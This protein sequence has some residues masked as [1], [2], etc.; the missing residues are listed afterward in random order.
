MS[1]SATD[2]TARQLEDLLLAWEEVYEQGQ[3]L[4]AEELCADCPELVDALQE[5]INVL[6]KME[7]RFGASSP[8]ESSASTPQDE[9]PKPQLAGTV[10][11][12]NAYRVNNLHA[13]GGLGEVYLAHDPD[14]QRDVAIKT[15]KEICRKFPDRKA[16]FL[17]EARITG[18]LE[19]PGIVPVYSLGSTEDG[20][21][22]YAMRFIRGE[23]LDDR[24]RECHA[25]GFR[26]SEL[27]RLLR[28][29]VSACRTV[30]Y[31]HSRRVLHCDIKPLNIM[32]GKFGETFVLDWGEALVINPQ[33]LATEG[34][35]PAASDVE[36][37]TD[38]PAG[39]T[40]PYMPPE[41]LDGSGTPLDATSDVY[42][43]GATLYK[44]LTGRDAF[45][46]SSRQQLVQRILK[47]EFAP[48]RE[49]NRKTSRTLVAIVG[50]AIAVNREER[51]ASAGA[52][53][54]D[55]Q[56]W[57]DDEPVACR[58]EGWLDWLGRTAR[59]HRA[60]ALATFAA[61]LA[62]IVATTL[63][64]VASVQNA[65]QRELDLAAVTQAHQRTD[66]ARRSGLAALA[67][68]AAIQI[69]RDTESCWKAMEQAAAN[70]KLPTWLADARTSRMRCEEL[71]TWLSALYA[72]HR[73]GLRGSSW[74]V[75]DEHGDQ[76]GRFPEGLL[77]E[78]GI[79]NFAHKSY[80]HGEEVEYEEGTEHPPV[81]NPS[82]STVFWSSSDQCRKIAYSVPIRDLADRSSLHGVLVMTVKLGDVRMLDIDVGG[83]VDREALLIDVRAD[84][85]DRTGTVLQ[86]PRFR[87]ERLNP[88][89]APLIAPEVV[90]TLQTIRSEASTARIVPELVENFIDPV[91]DDRRM[92]AIAPVRVR[93]RYI[94]WFAVVA[95]AADGVEVASPAE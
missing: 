2:Q 63:V 57:M 91:R 19:H 5:R 76:L 43:L 48:P 58:Q 34:P 11:I 38:S 8:M 40:V 18:Q 70:P 73:E 50:K 7:R 15:L 21:P 86:H 44:I 66:T 82:L 25:H 39:G 52:L 68:Y 95:E 36:E 13:A 94:G 22:L 74:F 47:G 26:P 93:N 46:G 69:E 53:A 23:S 3:N 30:H 1:S 56:A 28:H 35:V 90:G 80:F 85:K 29:L 6:L 83:S 51:Y 78:E 81:A 88:D 84:W 55:I 33:T 64:A 75:L 10:L 67:R 59:R 71:Q 20:Q 65:K 45:R 42:A 61:L 31:A 60:A 32:V 24:I 72:D 9:P 79:R 49:V 62:M 54:D 27:R 17:R 37:N 89:E 16:R 41:R 77:A 92:A 87:E 14:L 4:P 12:E